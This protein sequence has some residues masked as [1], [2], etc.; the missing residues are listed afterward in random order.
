MSDEPVFLRAD[1]PPTNEPLRIAAR[2]LRWFRAAFARVVG[3]VGEELGCAFE[4]DGSKLTQIFIRWLE[5]LDRQR[6]VPKE[7]RAAFLEFASSL[8]FRELISDLPIR[9]G[10][11]P[12]RAKRE[13]PGGFW[14]EA[15]ACMIFCLTVHSA[16]LEQ[17]YHV[18]TIIDPQVGDLRSWWSFRENAQEDHSFSA[19]F[20]QKLLCHEPNW[21]VP[22]QFRYRI[23]RWLLEPET[24]GTQ[25][26]S[27]P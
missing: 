17:E 18:A 22:E 23:G 7:E 10:G 20:F 12:V 3:R 27:P 21:F 14:P 4:I 26:Q 1:L 24:D 6:P 2:R 25:A 15:Y 8:A 9:T 19:G 11:S 16:T 13:M 5:A